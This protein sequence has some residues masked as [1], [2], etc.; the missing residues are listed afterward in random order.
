[1]KP[2]SLHCAF[3][4]SLGAAIAWCVA[5][6]TTDAPPATLEMVTALSNQGRHDEAATLNGR[7]LTARNFAPARGDFALQI[8]LLRDAG[9]SVEADALSHWLAT[10]GTARSISVAA[11]RKRRAYTRQRGELL[12]LPR[13]GRGLEDRRFAAR[14]AVDAE[15][16]LVEI[17]ILIAGTPTLAWEV[18]ETLGQ[19]R[20]ATYRLSRYRDDTFPIDHCLIGDGESHEHRPWHPPRVRN[21]W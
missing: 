15:G 10:R 17:E 9:R 1:M 12:R 14:Y 5:C 16:R 4:I 21:N 18:I 13:S 2:F 8:A 3:H 7:R 11:C 6:A 19:A 20:I